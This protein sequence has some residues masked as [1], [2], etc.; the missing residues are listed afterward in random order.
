VDLFVRGKNPGAA[1][2]SADTFTGPTI[3]R[4]IRRFTAGIAPAHSRRNAF[5]RRGLANV[6]TSFVNR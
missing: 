4:Q 2:T 5:G 1:K 6:H 3:F